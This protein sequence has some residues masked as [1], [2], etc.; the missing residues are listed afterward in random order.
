ML[1]AMNVCTDRAARRLK[2]GDAAASTGSSAGHLYLAVT[3]LAVAARLARGARTR[4]TAI[5][6]VIAAATA[7]SPGQLA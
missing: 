2:V 4:E 5:M 6:V 3:G 7:A 1:R